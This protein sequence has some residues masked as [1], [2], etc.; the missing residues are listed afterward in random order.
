MLQ[1]W[2]DQGILPAVTQ[3]EERQAPQGLALQP[4][5]WQHENMTSCRPSSASSITTDRMIRCF[6]QGATYGSRKCSGE[7]CKTRLSLLKRSAFHSICCILSPRAMSTT[8]K[9]RGLRPDVF[10]LHSLQDRPVGSHVPHPQ[11]GWR[12]YLGRWSKVK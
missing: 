3:Q 6:M 8:C 9:G 4:H 10:E 2:H 11:G 5:C 7:S 12:S 1:L